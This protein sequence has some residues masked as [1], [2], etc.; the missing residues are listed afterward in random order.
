MVLA[1]SPGLADGIA[2]ARPRCTVPCTT[3]AVADTNVATTIFAQTVLYLGTTP[4]A[5][6]ALVS[7]WRTNSANQTIT[8][9]F[10][11]G[12]T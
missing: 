4:P 7:V 9:P 3:A 12:G 2:T 8:L 10:E 5:A 11:A 6:N 1:L